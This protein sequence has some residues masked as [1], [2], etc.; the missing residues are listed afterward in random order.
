LSKTNKPFY[1]KTRILFL[2]IG[3]NILWY[4]KV[5]S[6]F[7]STTTIK[8]YSETK[9]QLDRFREYKNESYDEVI[10]KLVFVV[11]SYKKDPE[12]GEEAIIQIEKAR[13]RIAKGKF[14]TEADAKKR[15]GL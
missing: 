3:F 14:L 1:N 15:L 9:D 8:L 10:K 2:S 4:T 11:N 6:D 5:D 12:L 7:M 13:D